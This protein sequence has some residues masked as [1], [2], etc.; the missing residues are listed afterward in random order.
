MWLQNLRSRSTGRKVI[1]ILYLSRHHPP[2]RAKHQGTF[3]NHSQL[4]PLHLLLLPSL[5]VRDT[6]HRRRGKYHPGDRMIMHKFM[7]LF[8]FKVQKTQE[9]LLKRKSSSV[10]LSGC[11]HLSFICILLDIFYVFMYIFSFLQIVAMSLASFTQR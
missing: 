7:K 2:V 9:Y 11:N 6:R 10:P 1:F 3:V 8:C 5:L 4:R